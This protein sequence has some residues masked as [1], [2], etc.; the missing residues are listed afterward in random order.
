MWRPTAANSVLALRAEIIAKVRQFFAARG[1]MEVET[2]LLSHGT[3]TDPYVIAIPASYSG[4]AVSHVENVYLQTSPEYAMKRLL[5]A[6]SGPIYQITKAFRNESHGKNHNP[7]FSVLEWYRLGFDHHDLMN[8]MDELLQLVLGCPPAERLSYAMLMQKFLK[9]DPHQASLDDL[10][11]CARQYD[12]DVIA[13]INDPNTWLEVLFNQVIEKQIG[14]ARP[15][16]LYDFPVAQ[17]ALAKIRSDENPPLASRFE[18]HYR[19]L[20]LANGFHE[21]QD[22][23]EQRSRFE[24]DLIY[25]QAHGF[26]MVP[27]DENFLAALTA[28]LPDCSGVAL[29]IDRLVMLALQIND[30]AQVISFPFPRA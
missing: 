5:A 18:V 6:G 19:G 23:N 4:V 3:I 21:L 7:E 11:A 24:K 15:L 27:I 26:P 17:A 28:G 20:E 25:R 9:L 14:K 2:P 1:V 30:I 29:G 8:E 10:A 16:F 22:A 12:I 13:E